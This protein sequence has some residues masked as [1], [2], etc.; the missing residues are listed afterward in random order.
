MN[1]R[2]PNLH[3]RL[4]SALSSADSGSRLRDSRPDRP[5]VWDVKS[6][7]SRVNPTNVIPPLPSSDSM[8]AHSGGRIG[9]GPSA[10]FRLSSGQ[11]Q[12]LT[13]SLGL[14]ADSSPAADIV[15][16]YLQRLSLMLGR[17]A[18]MAPAEQDRE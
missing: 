3:G 16:R 4:F 2:R 1:A 14:P 12:W 6:F 7:N 5:C 18:G 11:G 10:I 8:P 9:V 15:F 17:S 13:V